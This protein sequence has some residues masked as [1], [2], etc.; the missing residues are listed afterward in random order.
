ML[1]MKRDIILKSAH[2]KTIGEYYNIYDNDFEII[3]NL[4]HFK[5]NTTKLTQGKNSIVL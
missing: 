3:I 1:G 5:N 4:I 2:I